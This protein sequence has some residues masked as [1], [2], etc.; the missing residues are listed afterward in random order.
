MLKYGE[1][2]FK[3]LAVWFLIISALSSC[4][5]HRANLKPGEKLATISSE[6]R[7][8]A[9][10]KG[11]VALLEHQLRPLDYLLHHP[12][13]KGLLV[14]HYMGT[15]KTY[16]GLGFGQSYSE[17]PVII[18]APS[19]LE[20]HWHNQLNEFNP[21]HPERFTFVSYE[22]APQ[23][24]GAMDLSKHVLL[25]DEAHNLVKKMRSSDQAS[26]E[27]Y[28]ELYLNL[29]NAYKILAL[30][31]TP[32]Y[33]DESDLAY[34][35]NLVAG[36][37]LMPFNKESFRLSY[38]KIDKGRQFSRGY[39]TE[40]NLMVL[41]LPV[42]LAIYGAA[43]FDVTGGIIG[44]VLGGLGMPLLNWSLPLSSFQMRELNVKE[45]V[46]Y[47]NQYI[48]YFK[49]NESQFKDFPALDFKVEEIS[50][51]RYQYSFFLRLV[52]GDLPVSDI[53]RLLKNDVTKRSDEIVKINSTQILEQLYS[54]VGAGRDIGN[55]DF[56]DK[57][58]STIEPPKFVK[59]YDD[60]QKNP[61]S[62]VIYS[63]YYETGI[64]AFEAF[65]KR[66]G[67]N[68]RYAIIH[69]K[70]KAQ[71][72]TNIVNAY[73]KGELKL[74]MLHPDITE[75]ISLKG[76]QYLDILEPMLNGTVLEQ[77]IGR[78]RRFQ[79]HS[80]LPKEK[81]S[82]RVRMWQ[83]T[84]SGWNY[85]ISDIGRANWYKRYREL[86]FLSRWG[87]GIAQI[88][89]NYEKKALNPEELALLKLRTLEKNL[90]MMQKVLTEES[91][92]NGYARSTP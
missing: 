21:S 27:R 64:L 73:N 81:Q 52:E 84:S 60:I 63:N 3:F 8:K 49:F 65:L 92:E 31:G 76:T 55:F 7:Q 43:L 69:P 46:P 13:Q 18:L 57:D 89:K 34:M 75:G 1:T 54:G 2:M 80:H 22:D 42:F 68:K 11:A 40:S 45:L 88:D 35:I 29:R 41:T 5:G 48:S 30:T 39:I 62:R 23:K 67:Y 72:I 66:Q 58:L 82:V 33:S 86:N 25:I 37:D 74:L 9:Q 17:Y 90:A 19:F 87:I 79:S 28:T 10:G 32:I 61:E 16:L 85:D 14:N 6:T 53:Q 44:G 12:G 59:I 26:N 36:K 4:S 24:L 15:G 50:Y 56:R 38:T 20:S 71:E 83:S 47:M 77:V 91:I 78:T 51:N 70:L